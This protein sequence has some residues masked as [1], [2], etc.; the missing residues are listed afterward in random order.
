MRSEA[1]R[2]DACAIEGAAGGEVLRKPLS[3]RAGGRRQR[4]LC[5][6]DAAAPDLPG[7]SFGAAVRSCVYP[8]VPA[9]DREAEL[10]ETLRALKKCGVLD[11]GS[12]GIIGRAHTENFRVSESLGIPG[13]AALG[14]KNEKRQTRR[15][16]V[17][18]ADRSSG[19]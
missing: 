6:G 4:A 5:R 3:R 1:V 7:E 8:G 11:A 14:H 10:P 12:G 19:V 2:K 16:T 17:M 13:F 15:K 9:K 18:S